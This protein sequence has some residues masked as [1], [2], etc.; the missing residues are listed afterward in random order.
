MGSIID[1]IVEIGTGL[2]HPFTPKEMAEL[3]YGDADYQHLI[4]I[5]QKLKR[6]VNQGFLKKTKEERVGSQWKVV[7]EVIM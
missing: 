1:Q 7:Y 4:A 2:D 6:L 5:H 3:V